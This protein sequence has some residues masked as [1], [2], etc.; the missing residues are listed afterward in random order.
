MLS[1]QYYFGYQNIVNQ[2]CQDVLQDAKYEL[3]SEMKLNLHL[4]TFKSVNLWEIK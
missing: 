2:G 1:K 4:L 3:K